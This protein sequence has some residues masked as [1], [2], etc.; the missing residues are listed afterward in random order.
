MKVEYSRTVLLIVFFGGLL[1]SPIDP[2][3]AA[4]TEQ[5]AQAFFKQHCFDCHSGTEPEG[6]FNLT[7]LTTRFGATEN[8]N[9]WLK[10][11]EQLKAGTMPPPDE[12]RP[13]SKQKRELLAWIDQQIIAAEKLR[14]QTEGRAVM[15]RLN[16]AEYANTIRD[17][18]Q[19]DVDLEGVLPDDSVVGGFDT[20]A[21]S[22]HF[23]SYQLAGY[24]EA[25]N[26]ALDAAFAN[27]PRPW[28]LDRR[29][30]PKKESVTRRTNVY[31]H[32]DD[33][34]A[35]FASDLASNIQIVFWNC[36]TRFPGKYR[37]R[38]SAYAYQTDEPVL[39][40]INGGR[41]NLGDPPYLID[42]FEVPPGEPTVVEFVTEMEARR[43][44]RLLVDTETRPR[45]LERR[46]GAADYEGPGLV[47]QWLEVEGPLLDS[48]PPPS[49]RL[50][51]GDLSQQPVPGDE[52]RRE[53]VSQQ[54]LA[55]AEQVLRTFARRAYRR[56]TTET[57]IELLLDRVR[58]QLQNGASFERALRVGLKAVLVSPHFLFLR[59][60][61]RP[62]AGSETAN[63]TRSGQL[64]AYSLASRLSYFLWSSMP[65]EELMSLAESGKLSQPDVLHDQVE[66]M[67][68]DEKAKAFGERFASQ[69]L[70]LGEIDATLPDRQLY[71]EYD[72]LL[73]ASML[74]EVHA[75]FAEVLR[76]DLSVTNF[77]DSDFSF[78]NERLAELYEVPDVAGLEFR[79]VS[80]PDDLHRGGVMTMAA[81]LKVTANGTTTSPIVRGAWVL[82]SLLG[83]PPPR[84]PAGVE[85]VEPD[86]RGATTIRDQLAKHREIDAC[87]SCHALIDP[88]GFA[89][90]NFDVI[91]GWRE[92]Y[93]SIGE[94]TPVQV[95]GRRMRYRHGPAVDASDVL[96]D[97]RRFDNIDQYKQLILADKDQIATAL[98]TKLLTYATGVAPTAADRSDVESIVEAARGQDYGFRTLVHETIQS[99][100]FR[101]K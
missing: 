44:I 59:E 92:N 78:L 27:G 39:F 57:E 24:L 91:G 86:I 69:W 81:V 8:R 82:D 56:P 36:L 13:D 21:Q 55:D 41:E 29:F 76:N 46:G 53:V 101:N 2:G 80:L 9:R 19:V 52:D 7:S 88:P 47:L 74:K 64:D 25:A 90:E 34:V 87:A 37:F 83:T 68:K 28:I 51:L 95:G 40:H 77:V 14:Q 62:V 35:I 61:V 16:Q 66:R 93:R 17:L 32:L 96:S 94:G 10:V 3:V 89:L 60:E 6:D 99:E 48:W 100:L 85:A 4:A 26:R 30:D 31:R 18:L 84:P 12:S 50:L 65:D 1:S 97:G 73:R 49:Y 67:L 22:L 63:Q 42:Y 72:K 45:D 79:R 43:N 70:G 33:G 58:A 71:P 38:L 54:P 75:F 5:S 23:S 15:R 20:A 98:T 11:A